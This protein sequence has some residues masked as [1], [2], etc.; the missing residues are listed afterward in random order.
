MPSLKDLRNRIASVKATQKITKAMQMV[1][2]AKLRRA[3]EAAEAA[4]PYS[5]RMGAVLANITQAIGGGGEA[6]ALMTGTGKDD[7]HLL[8]VCTAERGL[9]GGFN[10]QIARL[11]RDHIRKLLAD[12][13]QVKIIC[14]GKKGFDILR[15]DYAALIL[16]RVDLREVKTL[17]FV[18]ADGIAKKVIQLF[19]EGGFDICTLFYSQFKSVISQ[20]P[21]TQQ[22]IPA[23]VPTATAEATDGGSAVYEYEP[24][25]GE[26]LSD[27]IP[28]NISVQVFRALLENAAGE[29]GAKMSAMDNATRN[30][31]DMIN[32]LSITYNRQRQAQITK[33]LIEII[34]G[35]EAL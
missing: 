19:N 1:A 20:I 26:I 27:L 29:M 28:R 34:S 17:G 12:G 5:E 13:K 32:K 6:P 9:C 15:R 22:I 21:T 33:E 3:Q 31:G 18:N 23:G 25:P 2:A 16:E 14:V 8:V 24:E 30:A 35:A 7:V 11:A 10:S 4:R